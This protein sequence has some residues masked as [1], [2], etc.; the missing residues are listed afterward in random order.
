MIHAINPSIATRGWLQAV[1]TSG[2]QTIT[3]IAKRKMIQR[4]SI[5]PDSFC[6]YPSA[7]FVVAEDEPEKKSEV[8]NDF[9]TP[10]EWGSIFHCYVTST[11]AHHKTGWTLNLKARWSRSWDFAPFPRK[12]MKATK[13]LLT[14]AEYLRSA[15]G[16]RITQK[17]KKGRRSK[18]HRSRLRTIQA[19]LTDW[20]SQFD[21]HTVYVKG[22]IHSEQGKKRPKS[23]AFT[24][25]EPSHLFSDV[26]MSE[27]LWFIQT[28]VRYDRKGL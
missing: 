1:E 4:R 17:K 25:I 16:A 10:G 20:A 19:A 23:I 8:K 21:A 15:G 13:K 5:D 11:I 26:F 18:N 22:E 6:L 12:A 28:T 9:L 24:V 7:S 14:D 2:Q 27:R 3:V